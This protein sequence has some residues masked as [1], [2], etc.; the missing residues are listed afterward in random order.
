MNK[1]YNDL[2]NG[3][4][5]REID[6]KNKSLYGILNSLIGL[7]NQ[8]S[9]KSKSPIRFAVNLYA[10]PFVE[11]S[12]EK[13]R[14]ITTDEI[15][16]FAFSCYDNE[17]KEETFKTLYACEHKVEGKEKYF[18]ETAVDKIIKTFLIEAITITGVVMIDYINKGNDNAN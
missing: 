13:K 18:L 9:I 16:V 5:V 3:Q 6:L 15:L 17:R 10:R 8:N 1:E 2:L 7:V 4:A 12:N 11:V 14:K